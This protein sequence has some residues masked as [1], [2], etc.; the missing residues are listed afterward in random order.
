MPL[1]SSSAAAT[2]SAPRLNARELDWRKAVVERHWRDVRSYFAKRRIA[3][4]EATDLT[5]EVC[6]RFLASEQCPT[7]PLAYLYG[8]AAN[9]LSDFVS[10]RAREETLITIDS[11]LAS[12]TAERF[13]NA[14]NVDIADVLHTEEWLSRA[15]ARLARTRAAVLIAHKGQGLTYEEV[16]AELDLSVHTVEKYI[17]L[18]K[19][20]FRA[21]RRA[22]DW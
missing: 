12:V 19:A 14:F 17:T 21:F 15:L 18:A 20:Q 11:D 2:G 5:Q 9:V 8:I 10:E 6:A 3:W 22:C 1:G 4:R 7:V 16:A 13:E